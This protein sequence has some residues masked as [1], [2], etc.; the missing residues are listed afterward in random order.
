[1]TS[2]LLIWIPFI[3]SFCLIALARNPNTM[4]NRNGES[5]HPYLIPDFRANSFSF[6]PLRMMLA[7]SLS[8]IALLC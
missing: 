2:S 1:L 5:G 4:L 8:Y 6:S 7:I 3:S